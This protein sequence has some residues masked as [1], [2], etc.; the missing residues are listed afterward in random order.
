[1]ADPLVQTFIH[2]LPFTPIH[3]LTHMRTC[4]CTH[5]HISSHTRTYNHTHIHT[6]THTHT[7]THILIHKSL[8]RKIGIPSS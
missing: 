3:T 4:A 7:H 1:M 2:V 6:H 5:I 8:Y